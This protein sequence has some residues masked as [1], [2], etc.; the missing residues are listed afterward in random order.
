[1]LADRVELGRHAVDVLGQ[2][3]LVALRDLVAAL[4]QQGGQHLVLDLRLAHMSSSK[5][6][7]AASTTPQARRYGRAAGRRHRPNRRQLAGLDARVDARAV[8]AQ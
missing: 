3:L 1:V 2:A 4:A 6:P 7:G 8:D 5:P